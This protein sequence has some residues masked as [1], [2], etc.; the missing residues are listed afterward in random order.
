M[1]TTAVEDANRFDKLALKFPTK[2]PKKGGGQL[3]FAGIHWPAESAPGGRIKRH[4]AGVAFNEAR[5]LAVKGLT[6]AGAGLRG[7]GE[8]AALMTRWFGPRPVNPAGTDRD[9]WVGAHRILG[10]IETFITSDIKVYYRGDMSLIGKKDDYPGATGNLKARDVGGYAESSTGTLDSIVGLCKLF[11]AKQKGTGQVAMKLSGMDSVGGTLVHELSHNL[12]K[13][14]DH[15][16]MNGTDCYGTAQCLALAT[17]LP[18]RAWYNADNI[19]YFCEEAL[20]GAAAAVAA[21]PPPAGGNVAALR[22]RFG[23]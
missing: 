9:W 18:R 10:V 7:D 1:G 19:E 16:S 4:D 2:S 14:D 15:E 13:T 17:G 11:F 6:V 23:G 12:C 5:R 3:V 20:Y 21:A 8:A 22:A